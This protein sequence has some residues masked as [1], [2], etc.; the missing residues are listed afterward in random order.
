MKKT[1]RLLA[2]VLSLMM[3]FQSA[4]L[5]AFAEGPD[6]SSESYQIGIIDDNSQGET[7]IETDETV[8][9][10]D[11][12]VP[13]E[14]AGQI[15]I[16]VDYVNEEQN[17]LGEDFTKLQL[18]AF[19]EELDL[20]SAPVNTI[21]IA[22]DKGTTAYVFNRALLNG[23]TVE[24]IRKQEE[25]AY[26]TIRSYYDAEG[27]VISDPTEEQISAAIPDDDNQG[28]DSTETTDENETIT[29]YQARINNEWT[30]LT[31]D[32]TIQFVFDAKEA[33][34]VDVRA[35]YYNT[36][37]EGIGDEYIGLPLP[38]FTD[39]ILNLVNNGETRAVNDLVIEQGASDKIIKYTFEYAMINNRRI[40]ALK[41]EQIDPEYLEEGID[42]SVPVYSYSYKLLYMNEW[43][44]LT[45]DTTVRFVFS[46][47][48]R[49]FYSY[50]DATVKVT[51]RLQYKNA[52]PDTAELKV[53]QIKSGEIFETYIAALNDART[54]EEIEQNKVYDASNTYLFDVAFID[55]KYDEDG[56]P[57][58]GSEYEYQPVDGSVDI[59]IVIKENG[60]DESEVNHLTLDEETKASGDTTLEASQNA[61]KN[62]IEVTPVD[63][64]DSKD[65]NDNSITEFKLDGFSIISITGTNVNKV[66][67]DKTPGAAISTTGILGD[68]YSYGI[69]T[70]DYYAPGESESSFATKV[71][72][73]GG[74][75]LGDT[76]ARNNSDT[77]YW[78][79]GKWEGQTAKIK[80]HSAVITLPEG[81]EKNIDFKASDFSGIY[82]LIY[83]SQSDINT[84]VD[85]MISGT[86]S[87]TL[88]SR[89]TINGGNK[90]SNGGELPNTNGNHLYLDFTRAGAGTFYIDVPAGSN[91]EKVIATS[92][93]L[94][95][96]VNSDQRVVFNMKNT[97][98]IN[99]AKY[100]LSINGGNEIGTDE[101]VK[102]GKYSDYVEKVVFNC[103]NASNLNVSSSCG[104]FLAPK[105]A[106]TADGVGG[107]WMVS[108]TMKHQCE[109]HNLNAHI[110]SYHFDSAALGAAKHIDGDVL[111]EDALNQKFTFK[112]YEKTNNRWKQ[113]DSVNN[114]SSSITFKEI[115]YKNEGTHIYRITES[116][117]QVTVNGATYSPDSTIYYAKVVVTK[118]QMGNVTSDRKSVV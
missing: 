68:A 3:L 44:K 110:P 38:E 13:K 94:H 46:D 97:G 102:D 27:N 75:Q 86:M 33:T 69:V 18:P 31:E 84:A 113:I 109:W 107:G 112:L 72:H 55:C 22:N 6:S 24:G 19:E 116:S 30:Q 53:T 41:R 83:R 32:T 45:E 40:S 91:L 79:L 10:R 4:P 80:G 87:S 96:K 92:G 62:N 35:D 65:S 108:K 17:A 9:Y 11:E 43:K 2:I 103:P 21:R 114:V 54:Q 23:Q 48:S 61:S 74:G 39:D 118:S 34:V 28:S 12:K 5:A 26:E 89:T 99:V 56:N 117:G 78:M 66:E 104:V 63:S 95:L 101:I 50:E 100:M 52:V 25:E 90:G 77:Q 14:N 115:Q 29:T 7:D 76:N 64:T 57:I 67:I 36:F 111:T 105:A 20:I 98:Y 93:Q 82:E 70:E 37:S 58:E 81:V 15:S 106:A 85:N 59:K 8:R 16:D 51:A 49:Y 71:F 42:A 47:G 1:N 73:S 88:A 60:F